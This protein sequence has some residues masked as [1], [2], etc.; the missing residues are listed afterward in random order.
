MENF[1]NVSSR[2]LVSADVNLIEKEVIFQTFRRSVFV[3]FSRC[4]K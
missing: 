2:R 3:A 1:S 4:K